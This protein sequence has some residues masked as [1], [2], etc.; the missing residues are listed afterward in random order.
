RRF[1]ILNI[2]DDVTKECLGAI[3]ETSRLRIDADSRRKAKCDQPTQML[4]ARKAVSSQ[5]TTGTI[6]SQRDQFESLVA[7]VARLNWRTKI[8]RC[9]PAGSGRERTSGWP[10]KRTELETMRCACLLRDYSVGRGAANIPRR[11]SIHLTAAPRV[12]CQA[13]EVGRIE[14]SNCPTTMFQ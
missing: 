7:A 9:K 6:F 10:A 12:I 11:R 1:R 2:V 13:G 3:P 8:S 14:R 4:Q 5:E